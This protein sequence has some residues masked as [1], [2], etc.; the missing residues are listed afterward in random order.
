MVDI[1]PFMENIYGEIIYM[2][3]FFEMKICALNQ[4]NIDEPLTLRFLQPSKIS[5]KSAEKPA[6][7]EA[8]VV[9]RAVVVGIVATG[10]ADHAHLRDGEWKKHGMEG[11]NPTEIGFKLL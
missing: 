7:F 1:D 8:Q 10:G 5:E 4:M 11:S 9:G 3:P 2:I 6:P